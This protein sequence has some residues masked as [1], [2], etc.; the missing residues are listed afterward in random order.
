MQQIKSKTGQ[1]QHSKLGVY[2]Q[3]VTQGI[4]KAFALDR[5]HGILIAG[6]EKRGPAHHAG[7][8]TGDI[9]LSIDQQAIESY[10]DLSVMLNKTVPSQVIMVKIWRNG[11]QKTLRI[12]L[13]QLPTD[14][15]IKHRVTNQQRY[16]AS[17]NKRLEGMG[18]TLSPLTSWQKTVAFASRRTHRA[19]G[20]RYGSQSR[21][22][23]WRYYYWR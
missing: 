23:A 17:P 3:P 18:A 12:K 22:N 15:V 7:L 10:S 8:K 5:T 11:T 19:T 21:F 2:I 9:L 1:A 4:A 13:G 16:V 14:R 20:R 6:L